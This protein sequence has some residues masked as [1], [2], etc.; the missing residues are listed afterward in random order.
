MCLFIN[1]SN[2][3]SNNSK[4]NLF[5]VQSLIMTFSIY[6]HL[7]MVSNGRFEVMHGENVTVS[8]FYIFILKRILSIEQNIKVSEKLIYLLR[9]IYAVLFDLRN[10]PKM[11]VASFLKVAT[12]LSCW[13]NAFISVYHFL[14]GPLLFPKKIL[15]PVKKC[16]QICNEKSRH[17]CMGAYISD[18]SGF[19]V[20]SLD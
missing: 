2:E 7:T 9:Y 5:P 18:Q 15:L 19:W 10:I 17:W 8:F 3:M 12:T 13:N 4:R 1:S 16:R 11:S 6:A 20:F 14:V